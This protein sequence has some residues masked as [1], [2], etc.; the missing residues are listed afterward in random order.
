MVSS[1]GGGLYTHRHRA[2]NGFDNPSV[3]CADLLAL[4]SH[5]RNHLPEQ[6]TG[7]AGIPVHEMNDADFLVLAAGAATQGASANS[8][9]ASA[10]CC[11]ASWARYTRQDAG[12]RL[13]P[14]PTRPDCRPPGP[15][16]RPWTASSQ[17]LWGPS[18]VT[19]TCE[20]GPYV[21]WSS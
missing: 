9:K 4:I 20:P 12:R 8:S 19:R 7:V 13:S 21:A 17:K 3:Y 2:Q 16:W 14:P 15:C 18:L 10:A 11:A 5:V 1:C 6:H